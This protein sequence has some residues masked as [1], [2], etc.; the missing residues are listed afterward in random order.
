MDTYV[1]TGGS[2]FIGSHVVD[3]I[4]ARGG[5]A[6]V[7]D[8]MATG[9]AENLASASGDVTVWY[10]DVRDESMLRRAMDGATYVLHQA[11]LPSVPRSVA[12]PH[13]TNSV[14]VAGTLCVLAAARDVG[15]RRVVLA[16]SSSV[17]G[18]APGLPRC[19]S[20]APAPLSPYAASKYAAEMYARVFTEVYDLETVCLRYFNVFGPRQDAGS[21]YAAAVPR[22][23][24]ATLESKELVIHGDGKQTR[25][26]TYVANVV[27]ANLLACEAGGEVG[28]VYNVAGGMRTSVVD[29][30]AKIGEAVGRV[31][32]VRYVEPRAGDV[33]HSV[34]DISLARSE[35]GYDPSV[36]IDTG[37]AETAEWFIGGAG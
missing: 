9:R 25:D 24:Q 37:L 15:V 35:L 3:A 20:Q 5:R 18:S 34:A 2:G 12:D 10:A 11:A 4:L 8:S 30:V 29:L 21:S 22:F 19:E 31:P 6:V 14:N 7:V 33:E 23:M 28:A 16:S 17:Y 1:V 32:R 26:F 27:S 13:T 36:N